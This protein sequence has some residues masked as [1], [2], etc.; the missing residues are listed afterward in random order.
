M[1]KST[2]MILVIAV[3]VITLAVGAFLLIREM[4]SVPNAS[5]AARTN[6][7]S[8]RTTQPSNGKVTHFLLVCVDSG[9]TA[10]LSPFLGSDG[11]LMLTI[12]EGARKLVVTAFDAA[13]QVKVSRAYDDTLGHVYRDG[14]VELLKKTLSENF[15]VLPDYYAVFKDSDLGELKDSSASSLRELGLSE[16][17][18]LAKTLTQK[19]T[20]DMSTS[21]LLGLAGSASQLQS[22][23]SASLSVPSLGGYE[24][25]ELDG[26]TVLVPDLE[27]NAEA[28]QKELYE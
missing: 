7:V 26:N 1:R 2:L 15:G 12:N 21:T 10:A 3:I 9:D 18:A 5:A 8:S 19:A 28:L 13:T 17:T 23:K 4:N 22:Y 27:A 11:V 25:G 24:T 6:S 14:G 20:T 16:L